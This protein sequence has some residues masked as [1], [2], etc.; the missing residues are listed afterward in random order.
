[1]GVRFKHHLGDLE[2]DFMESAKGF[3]RKAPAA[4]RDTTREGWRDVRR[5]SRR[6]AGPH[7]KNFFKR[8]TMERTDTL[9]YEY[10]PEGMP[11]SEYVGVGYRNGNGNLDMPQSAD[12]LAESLERRLSAVIDETWQV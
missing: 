4:V 5:T 2:K 10:G 12:G 11:K 7:G 3:A 9:V 6:R 8:I 1:M